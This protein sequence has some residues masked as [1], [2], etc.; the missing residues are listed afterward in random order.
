MKESSA[1][2]AECRAGEPCDCLKIVPRDSL[3]RGTKNLCYFVITFNRVSKPR[4]R[5]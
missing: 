2:R 4:G 3:P 5:G 1:A